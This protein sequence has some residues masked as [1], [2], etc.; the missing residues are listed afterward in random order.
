MKKIAVMLVCL[1]L[2]LSGCSGEATQEV[3]I[4]SETL[5]SALSSV[6]TCGETIIYTEETDPNEKLGRP[7]N[8]IGKADFEDTRCEQLG[9]YYTG[10][11]FEYFSSEKNCDS[12]H[13]YLLKLSDP[14]LG[15]FG[16]N[17]YIY[18]YSTVILRVDYDLTP[19]QAEEYRDAMT[20]YLGEEPEQNY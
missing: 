14:S 11:T 1:V 18:K 2:L 4:T 5:L 20:A 19:E 12:R 13:E 7:D 3:E 9:E 10:G 17:Q 6:P 8:Y 15:A 16:V